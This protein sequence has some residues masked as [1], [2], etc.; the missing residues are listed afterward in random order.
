MNVDME[1]VFL[2]KVDEKQG[3]LR[4]QEVEEETRIERERREGEEERSS[5]VSR[6]EELERTKKTWAANNGIE[7]SKLLGRSTESLDTKRKKYTLP[8]NP[9]RFGRS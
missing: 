3:R 6:R 8:N 1:E 9:F 4:R 7:V 2:K 5:I